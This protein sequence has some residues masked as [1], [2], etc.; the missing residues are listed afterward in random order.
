[1]REQLAWEREIPSRESDRR[2]SDHRALI[3]AWKTA[4]NPMIGERLLDEARWRFIEEEIKAYSFECDE[5][6]AYVL[7]LRLLTRYASFDRAGGLK[8]LEEVTIP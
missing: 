1:M 2:A 7:K 3:E 6:T 5:F 8:I 4:A